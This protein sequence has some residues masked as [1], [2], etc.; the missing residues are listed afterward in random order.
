MKVEKNAEGAILLPLKLTW[1][2]VITIQ[3]SI[4]KLLPLQEAKSIQ[5]KID[6]Y[7][8]KFNEIERIEKSS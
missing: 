4:K 3:E 6:D 8:K 2:E 7:L 5:S 1:G